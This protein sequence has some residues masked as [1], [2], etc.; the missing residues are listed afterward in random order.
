MRNC[1]VQKISFVVVVLL[2]KIN[3]NA[4]QNSSVRFANNTIAIKKQN[5][6]IYFYDS[7]GELRKIIDLKN[8]KVT[9]FGLPKEVKDIIYRGEIPE[10]IE[11]SDETFPAYLY[12][13]RYVDVGIVLCSRQLFYNKIGLKTGYKEICPNDIVDGDDYHFGSENLYKYNKYGLLIET[14]AI[15]YKYNDKGQLIEKKNRNRGSKKVYRNTMYS[16]KDEK[17]TECIIHEINSN[18]IYNRTSKRKYIYNI[19]GLLSEII[20]NKRSK[21]VLEYNKHNKIIKVSDVH[22]WRNKTYKKPRLIYHYNPQNR[23]VK[24][25]MYVHSSDIPFEEWGF[26]Y[27][28]YGHLTQKTLDGKIIES[29]QY[30][31]KGTLIAIESN[32]RWGADKTLVNYD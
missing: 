27:D 14:E 29:Y 20:K 22:T 2:L 1:L 28:V 3:A 13:E 21:I 11:V 17:L 7:L 5:D 15:V 6:S 4:Q 19:K 8:N 23:I 9:P 25:S 31:D 18:P 24:I 12:T 16:Y 30:D 26:V 10:R 32:K